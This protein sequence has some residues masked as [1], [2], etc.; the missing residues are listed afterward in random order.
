MAAMETNRPEPV[1]ENRNFD[2]TTWHPLHYPTVL[3]LQ[4]L[5]VSL[6]PKDKNL[7]NVRWT[8]DWKGRHYHSVLEQFS[9]LSIPLTLHSLLFDSCKIVLVHSLSARKSDVGW[10]KCLVKLSDLHKDSGGTSLELDVV[11]YQPGKAA[12]GTIRFKVDFYDWNSETA[13]QLHDVP[14]QSLDEFLETYRSE[15][16]SLLTKQ[17]RSLSV[18]SSSSSLLYESNSF[19]NGSD[20][21]SHLF[22]ALRQ[23]GWGIN[24][25]DVPKS[26]ALIRKYYSVYSYPTTKDYV[27]SVDQLSEALSFMQPTMASYGTLAFRFFGM[28]SISDTVRSNKKMVMKHLNLQSN[29]M[30]AWEYSSGKTATQTILFSHKP[31]FFVFHDSPKQAVHLCVRG[32]FSLKDALTDL[33]GEY[34][35]FMGGLAHKGMLQAALYIRDHFWKEMKGWIRLTRSKTLHLSGHSLGGAVCALFAMLIRDD[36]ASEM[37]PDFRCA[38]Y[39]FACPPCVSPDLAKRFEDC[40]FVY[41]NQHDPVPKLSYGAVMDFKSMLV[42]SSLLVKDK[43]MTPEDRIEALHQHAE[44]LKRENKNI[45]LVVPGRIYFMYKTVEGT[46]A[47]EKSIREHFDLIHLKLDMVYH[48]FPNKYHNSLSKSIIHLSQ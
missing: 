34:V 48:H 8:I 7:Q 37:G 19:Q 46:Y 29:E 25:G 45:R 9:T 27:T 36:L 11:E 39:L 1:F 14:R 35:E 6:D 41:N 12:I 17:K 26:M 5:D 13:A 22:R 3:R 24:L 42:H 38:A 30:L 44:M 40:I 20:Q 15:P 43:S 33:N 47:V 21:L 23:T 10:A 32:T 4:I 31:N 16:D 2:T 28:G 18:S